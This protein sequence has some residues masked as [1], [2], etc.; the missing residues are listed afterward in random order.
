MLM[1]NQN[2]AS[3]ENVANESPRVNTK[4]Q[5]K[6]MRRMLDHYAIQVRDLTASGASYQRLGFHVLP[7]MRHI[8]IGSAN[9]VIQFQNTYL[10]VIGEVDRAKAL[11]SDNLAERW[12]CGEG[13]TMVSLN[14]DDL[15]SDHALISE[16]QLDPAPII[17]ARRKV[18]MPDGSE[19]ETDSVCFY[20]FRPAR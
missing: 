4:N 14:S 8:E 10:E 13:L 1:R 11:V 15:D 9:R 17:S 19:D 3:G 16:L 20:I 6:P 7:I 18:T 5:P 12:L 2:P